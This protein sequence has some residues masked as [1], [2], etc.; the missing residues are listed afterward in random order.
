MRVG[1]HRCQHAINGPGQQRELS[2]AGA[3][4]R[5]RLRNSLNFPMTDKMEG[6]RLERDS[7]LYRFYNTYRSATKTASAPDM[8]TTWVTNAPPPLCGHR[9]KADALNQFAAM[10]LAVT[11]RCG[12]TGRRPGTTF[13]RAV[14]NFR[15]LVSGIK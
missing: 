7:K 5:I 9:V 1:P 12:F 11:P 13:R 14:G 4:A 6:G 10:L 15:A 3:P 2:R 8:A